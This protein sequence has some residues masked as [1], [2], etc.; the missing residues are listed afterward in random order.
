[1]AVLQMSHY[2]GILEM[3]DKV[4]NVCSSLLGG[5][6]RNVVLSVVHF[7]IPIDELRVAEL[8]NV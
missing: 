2:D 8:H 6:G 7:L 5:V 4:P 3:W 1:M